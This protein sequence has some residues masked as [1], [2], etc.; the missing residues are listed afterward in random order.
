MRVAGDLNQIMVLDK[1]SLTLLDVMGCD[2]TVVNTARVSFANDDW[3]SDELSERDAKLLGYLAKNG[4][5]SPFYHPQLTFR[6]RAPI[7]VQ[8]QFVTHKVGTAMNSEST[9]YTEIEREFYVPAEMRL[10]STSNRQGS[11]G[12]A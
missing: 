6:V 7:S 11:G 1:G 9:R 8:R 12:R 2:K 3:K 10:Q 5:V 4:H